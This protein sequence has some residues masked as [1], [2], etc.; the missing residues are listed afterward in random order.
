MAAS[1]TKLGINH[2]YRLLS[3]RNIHVQST[4]FVSWP[5]S[6][7][8]DKNE[9]EF[10]SEEVFEVA[11]ERNEV[12]EEMIDKMRNVSRLPDRLRRRLP[13]VNK[14]PDSNHPKF[15]QL[16]F[17]RKMYAKFGQESG[18]DARIM[19][20]TRS[21]IR[22]RIEE[23]TILEPSLQERLQKAEEE[24]IQIEKYL[25]QRQE[26]IKANMAKMPKWIEEYKAR[27]SKKLETQKKQQDKKQILLEQAREY[28]GYAIDP[29]DQKFIRMLEEKEEEEKK[30]LKK[31]KKEKRLQL[32]EMYNVTGKQ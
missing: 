30:L 27:E 15:D 9:E 17:K 26:K 29:R 11:D 21:E 8:T 31:K 7:K 2:L 4:L 20:P 16:W 1:M 23:D 6:E 5:F 25:N 10:P 28:F 13:H 14:M 12:S 22:E 32:K 3:L 24:K 19:W 18:V